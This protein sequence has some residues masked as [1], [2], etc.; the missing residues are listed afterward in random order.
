MTTKETKKPVRSAQADPGNDPA[1]A[2]LIRLPASL[3]QRLGAYAL[4]AFGGKSGQKN[5][6]II[7]A[8]DEWLKQREY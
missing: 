1:Q 7:Q 5:N 8:L 3:Q 4:D 6:I 2:T